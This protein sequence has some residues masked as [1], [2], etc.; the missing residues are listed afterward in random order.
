[1]LVNGVNPVSFKGTM[2]V[3]DMKNGRDYHLNNDS[4]LGVNAK[5]TYTQIIYNLPQEI[6]ENGRTYYEPKVYNVALDV[7]TILNAYNATKGNK[8]TVDLT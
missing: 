7:N 8:L 3:T 4:I 6:R 1:M 5:P 2:V